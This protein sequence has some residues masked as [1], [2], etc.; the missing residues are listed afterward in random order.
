[1]VGNIFHL[2]LITVSS[3][4]NITIITWD[5]KMDDGF[6]MPLG[7]RNHRKDYRLRKGCLWKQPNSIPLGKPLSIR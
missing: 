3:Q 2:F 7:K 5:T 6:S 4:R 1:M